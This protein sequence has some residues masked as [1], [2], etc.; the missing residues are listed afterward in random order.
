M[1]SDITY[2]QCTELPVRINYANTAVI[3]DKVYCGGGMTDHSDEEYIVYC[4]DPSRDNWTTLPPLPV[5]WFGLGQIS[6]KLVAI[7]GVKK[8]DHQA[9]NEICTYTKVE[10]EN[11]SHANSAMV[12]RSLQ[13]PVG[14]YSGRWV[15]NTNSCIYSCS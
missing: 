1:Q 2:K 7:G 14:T 6:G 10:A 4:Y 15:R 3:D 8:S 11:S 12:T 5:K 13:P 9:T